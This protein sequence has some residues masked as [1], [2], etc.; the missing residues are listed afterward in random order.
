M[1]SGRGNLSQETSAVSMWNREC[2]CFI[3][4]SLVAKTRRTMCGVLPAALGIFRDLEPACHTAYKWQKEKEKMDRGSQAET[5]ARNVIKYS[6]SSLSVTTKIWGFFQGGTLNKNEIFCAQQR[7]KEGIYSALFINTWRRWGAKRWTWHTHTQPFRTHSYQARTIRFKEKAYLLSTFTLC[8]LAQPYKYYIAFH[9]T[10]E[11]ILCKGQ[12]T[13]CVNC[14]KDV[15]FWRKIC[16]G[17]LLKVAVKFLFWQIVGICDGRSWAARY[18]YFTMK[19]FLKRT[20]MSLACGPFCILNGPCPPQRRRL[21]LQSSEKSLSPQQQQSK[22]LWNFAA[23]G[24]FSNFSF[25]SLLNT[26]KKVLCTDLC[27][28]PCTVW[29]T[30]KMTRK[31]HIQPSVYCL[32]LK[33]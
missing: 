24:H 12:N 21:L 17:R 31:L 18:F 10:K 16:P 4:K 1:H 14:G 11:T 3:L 32:V 26:V 19:P 28:W 6:T 29:Q 23:Q 30:L 22:L 25:F 13:E 5:T 27:F 15:A 20:L 8:L 33:C 9:K 2:V 7:S